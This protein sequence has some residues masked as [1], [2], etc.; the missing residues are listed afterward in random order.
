ML[1]NVTTP[2]VRRLAPFLLLLPLL[3]LTTQRAQAADTLQVG[4]GR[5][6][7][8]SPTGYYMQGWV[9]SDAVLRGVH[10]RIEAR[11]IVLK[12]GTQ[13]I[14][15]VAEDLNGIAGGVVKSAALRLAN[16]GF[17]ESNIIVS[18]S[19]THAAPSGYYPFQTYNT[20]FMTTS[21]LTDQNVTG[22]LDP[23][24]YSFEVRQLVLAIQRADDD[25][26]PGKVGWATTKLSGLTANR[27][28]EAHLRDHGITK[29]FG[30]GKVSDD[31]KGYL[32][33]IDPE[34]QVMRVD[35]DGV[36]PV[37]MWSTFADHGTVNKFQFGIYNADHHGSA[38]RLVEQRIRAL[39]HVPSKQDIVNAYGNTDE[40]DQSAGLTR[41]GPAAAD[42]VGR[43]EADA[44]MRAWTLA[45]KQLDG[46]P[47]LATRWTR[48][49]F[50]GQ[51]TADGP[52][53][54][55][56][57]PGLPLFTG[58]EEGRGPLYDI[59]KQPFEGVT[60]PTVDPLDM[61]QGHKVIVPTGLVSPGST[62]KAV[63]LTVARVGNHL[64]AT[65][66]G[67]MTVDMGRRVRGAVALTALGHGIAG[68]QL[69]GLANEYLSYFTSPQEYD[70]QHYEGGST[71]YGR[72]SSVLLLEQLQ[73]LT[74]ALVNGTSAV[75]P[76]DADPRNGANDHGARFGTGAAHGSVVSQPGTTQ[77]FQRAQLVWDGGVK[78]LDMRV[79][80][81]FVSVER[82][83][84][85][86]ATNDFGLQILWKVDDNGRYTAEWE[87]PR[88]QAPGS[89]RFLVQANHY[90]FRSAPFRVT[91]ATT[92]SVAASK[93][94]YPA[95]VTNVD[96]TNRP[97]YA[98]GASISSTTAPGG[99]HD[100]YGNCNGGANGAADAAA[101]PSV[102]A[103]AAVTPRPVAGGGSPLPSTGLTPWVAALGLLLLLTAGAARS[104][105]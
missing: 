81:P 68:V 56:A 35:K 80:K 16:R 102:C 59:T 3:F 71:M 23:Q 64:I 91:P 21:T 89:Y 99:P 33:T 24:L 9:R 69:S 67:E 66:P 18:A 79:G 49:C 13:K 36:G 87:V 57:T 78:G 96:L 55:T 39:G 58:S 19:H 98:H 83:G 73:L 103:R 104:R 15:L 30:Q 77:R 11:A 26:A 7:I 62:P 4:V 25:L 22:A 95:A 88:D 54:S 92:L 40:G 37:G 72:E 29:A 6:D 38:T 45:G 74:K 53:S 60:S 100:R 10:T 61:P 84:G 32:D 34:V 90:T 20:V 70:A 51:D 17:S 85:G 47:A 101:D 48:M 43:V 105:S 31:P 14:A 46:N 2:H 75:A 93:V 12:R 42:Y 50:C 27:S 28:L 44:F 1:P 63:P 97:V 65:I 76:Y 8:T 41:S 52:V 86:V 5:A 82:V 94:R